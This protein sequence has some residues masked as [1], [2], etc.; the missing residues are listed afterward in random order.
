MI[1]QRWTF[2]LVIIL[3][4]ALGR[5]AD[6]ECPEIDKLREF[7]KQKQFITLKFL[8]L[9][10]SDIFETVDS[11]GG[12]LQA[13]REGRFRLT[14][15]GQ[16]LVSDGIQY[17]SYSVENEQVLVDSVA[18][19]GDWNP[20]TLIYDPEKVYGCINQKV[21]EETL[22]FDMVALDSLTLPQQFLMRVHRTGYVPYNLVY[23]DDNGSR[24]ALH[25][26][27]FRRP[28]VLPDSLFEFHPDPGV[29]VIEMP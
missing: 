12:T 6:G 15:P 18:K 9:T 24:I 23:Y 11:L 19:L 29:E 21:A 3:V 25:I 2:V 1:L 26:S 16:V 10:H 13:G 20:L 8:Q 4:I 14:M 5:P 27:D 7:Y 17:W 28:S 22:E